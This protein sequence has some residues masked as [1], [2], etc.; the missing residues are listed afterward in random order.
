MQLLLG[1]AADVAD[2][3]VVL[4]SLLQLHLH[5]GQLLLEVVQLHTNGL[6]PCL[7]MLQH[8]IAQFTPKQ[9]HV[10]AIA[11][12]NRAICM[13]RPVTCTIQVGCGHLY[14]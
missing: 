1:L 8:R 13:L 6:T 5:L 9:P 2:V 12:S 10:A 11:C 4:L 7:G 3:G 14:C